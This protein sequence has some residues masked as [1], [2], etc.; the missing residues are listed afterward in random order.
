[1]KQKDE[2]KTL[3][4]VWNAIRTTAKPRIRERQGDVS[5]GEKLERTMKQG[6]QEFKQLPEYLRRESSRP[7]SVSLDR[8]V[9]PSSETKRR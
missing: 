4:R 8:T 7:Q 5:K 1:V 6:A 3:R 9:R 2:I